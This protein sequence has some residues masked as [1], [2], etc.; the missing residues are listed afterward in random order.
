MSRNLKCENCLE[1]KNVSQFNKCGE[2]AFYPNCKSCFLA[3]WRSD[4]LKFWEDKAT[5]K[6]AIC[7]QA[8][9]L[10]L[11]S[12]DSYGIPYKNCRACHTARIEKEYLER[13]AKPRASAPKK[14]KF[15]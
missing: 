7:L 3:Q 8:V 15:V 5:R 10:S 2:N 6:C 4:Q 9:P 14:A 13:A 12:K 1:E 11:Y